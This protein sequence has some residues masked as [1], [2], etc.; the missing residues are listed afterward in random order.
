MLT[1]L[2]GF[3]G[4]VFAT[5]SG[6]NQLFYLP[7][8]G[9]LPI[10]YVM[11]TKLGG[12][13]MGDRHSDTC[14]WWL[15]IAGLQ[16]VF[17][18]ISSLLNQTLHS[19]Y[20]PMTKNAATP[21]ILQLN[22]TGLLAWIPISMGLITIATFHWKKRIRSGLGVIISTRPT[23]FDGDP[24]LLSGLFFNAT[25]PFLHAIIIVLAGVS[26][27]IG[28]IGHSLIKPELG[29]LF[30]AGLLPIVLFMLTPLKSQVLKTNPGV[31]KI[32]TY[33][34]TFVILWLALNTLLFNH[35][36]AGSLTIKQGSLL[37]N[38]SLITSFVLALNLLI[39]APCIYLLTPLCRGKTI[40]HILFAC[41]WLPTALILFQL[42]KAH[43]PALDYI[44]SHLSLHYLALAFGLVCTGVYLA[45]FSKE[46]LFQK[47][48]YNSIEGP[49]DMKKR[50][51]ARGKTVL[52][53]LTGMIL[54]L[55]CFHAG[56]L[57]GAII[58]LGLWPLIFL[59][60]WVPFASVICLSRGRK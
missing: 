60:T 56:L 34:T 26:I 15:R 35:T 38:P 2:I 37:A 48:L 46:D 19:L 32:V 31:V 24:A 22:E 30:F 49:G 11:L 28:L 17:M 52:L 36:A 10:T 9:L 44:P 43:L 20:A 8:L 5:I 45:L 33:A 23:H 59:N 55:F 13:H 53:L 47:C 27:S 18:G 16:V 14:N 58:Y 25:L 57:V 51:T 42:I 39:V 3:C 40:R 6:F 12:T 1:A 21:V 7:L 4:M 54:M 29:F 50:N 41:L